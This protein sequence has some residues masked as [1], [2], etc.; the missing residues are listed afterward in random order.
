[1]QILS[2][3]DVGNLGNNNVIF[4]ADVGNLGNNNVILIAD[5]RTLGNIHGKKQSVRKRSG[6]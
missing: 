4:I 5:V 6:K 1:M 3:A 2:I